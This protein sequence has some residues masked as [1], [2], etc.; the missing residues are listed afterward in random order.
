MFG[1]DMGTLAKE[2]LFYNQLKLVNYCV[3]LRISKS[4]II[5]IIRSKFTKTRKIYNFFEVHNLFGKNQTAIQKRSLFAHSVQK[6]CRQG[7]S[8]MVV[9]LCA[10]SKNWILWKSPYFCIFLHAAGISSW[11]VDA[12]IC[13]YQFPGMSLQLTMLQ[14]PC[15]WAKRFLQL[16]HYQ[17][18][19]ALRCCL[20]SVYI[21]VMGELCWRH[22]L[23]PKWK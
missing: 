18:V 17:Y 9:T 20:Q 3:A 12:E 6:T 23:S 22:L 4:P 13:C 2:W 7:L 11:S 10:P 1:I 16:Q 14:H 8:N 19:C 5:L 15:D 21:P